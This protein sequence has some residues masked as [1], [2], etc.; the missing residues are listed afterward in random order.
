MIRTGFHRLVCVVVFAAIGAPAYAEPAASQPPAAAPAQRSFASAKD[1]TDAF[2]A[3]LGSND[4]GQ[5]D[6]L[7]GPQYAKF[8]PTDEVTATADRKQL[9]VAAKEALLLREDAPDR[10]TVVIGAQAWP[11]PIPIVLRSGRW[12]FDT[13]AGIDELLNRVV[14]KHEL[15]AIDLARHFVVAQVEYASEDRDG[16]QVLEYAQRIIS[17][18]GKRDGLHWESRDGGV[19]PFGPFVSDAGDY[20]KGRQP[21]D[22]FQGY[23]FKVLKRQGPNPPGGAYDYVINGN[24]IAGYALLAWPADYGESGVMSFVVNQQGKVFQKDLGSKTAEIAGAMTRY[25]PD[26]SWTLVSD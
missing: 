3:A 21:G 20:A 16:D 14:G 23:Y 10:I 24:M 6:A 12:Q 15:A 9:A 5:L 17:T 7:F 26:A 8:E 4:A 2:V 11:F 13:A 19:S 25:D 18:P 1:A 22:P